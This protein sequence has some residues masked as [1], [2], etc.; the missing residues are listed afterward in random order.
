MSWAVDFPSATATSA[1]TTLAPSLANA[2]TATWPIPEAPPVTSATLPSNGRGIIVRFRPRLLKSHSSAKQ[3]SRDTIQMLFLLHPKN[4]TVRVS[5]QYSPWPSK[6]MNPTCPPE[7]GISK[8]K[9][10]LASASST[11]K[12][13]SARNG[14]FRAF[15]SSAGMRMLLRNGLQLHFAQ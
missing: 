9:L 11:G 12:Q 10:G 8:C 1:I 7:P 4:E 15:T 2:S 13:G 3:Q 14:S 6:L 5:D